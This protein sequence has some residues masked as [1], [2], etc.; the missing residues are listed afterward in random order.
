MKMKL[1]LAVALLVL[2]A[3]PALGQAT[4]YFNNRTP[5][6]APVRD[7]H[8]TRLSGAAYLAQLYAGPPGEALLPCGTARPFQTGAMAGY[9]SPECITVPGV[10]ESGYAYVEMR[11]WRASDG[12]TYEQAL[13]A[14]GPCGVSPRVALDGGG[15]LRPP[16]LLTGLQP[17]ALN[18]GFAIT[19]FSC[20]T[21]HVEI[22]WNGGGTLQW[23][24]SVTGPWYDLTGVVSPAILPTSTSPTF[25]RL[26][27]PAR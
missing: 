9:V 15:H 11:A 20:A 10:A 16:S 4:F 19:G 14:A 3:V 21:D 25:F 13:A 7:F 17:F 8:G 5:A 26:S 2:A 12:A 22:R 27:R 18:A 1:E 23:A 24:H 6:D